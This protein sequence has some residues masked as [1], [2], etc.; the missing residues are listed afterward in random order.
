MGDGTYRVFGLALALVR[1]SG[2]VLLIDEVENGLHHS[3]QEEVW[4]A[5]FS[6]S[7]RLDVQVFATTHSWDAVV[8]F[9]AAANQSSTKGMLYRLEREPDGGIYAERYTEE[10]V[11]V[12]ADHQIEVR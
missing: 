2:G 7:V 5:L 1:A 6:L 3:V 8:G 9:Q 4:R 12:A 10:E 11:A